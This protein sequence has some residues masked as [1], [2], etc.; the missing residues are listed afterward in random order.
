MRTQA[1]T[2]FDCWQNFFT[3]IALHMLLPLLPL[4]LELWFANTVEA[5]SAALTAALYS[6]AIGLS[7]QFKVVLG[8]GFLKMR[9]QLPFRRLWSYSWG[10]SLKD[11]TVMYV[12]KRNS[13]N[14]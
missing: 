3:C 9:L 14:F 8:V 1:K 11:T 13:L 2:T 4:L 7:S 5:K 10:I 12:T 6:L